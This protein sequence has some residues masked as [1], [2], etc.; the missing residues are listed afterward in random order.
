MYLDTPVTE[1]EIEAM[2]DK[3]RQKMDI[4][5]PDAASQKAALEAGIDLAAIVRDITGKRA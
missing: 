2:K 4:P 1:T 5:M 3:H